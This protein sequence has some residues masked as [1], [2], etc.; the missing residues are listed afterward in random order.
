MENNTPYTQEE[1][2]NLANKVIDLRNTDTGI[3]IQYQ[4]ELLEITKNN[5]IKILSDQEII[6][7]KIYLDMLELS[8][9]QLKGK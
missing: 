9:E 2:D 5:K 8:L 3:Q 4:G 1:L 7:L 6:A